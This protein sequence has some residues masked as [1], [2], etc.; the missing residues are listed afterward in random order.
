MIV[1]VGEVQVIPLVRL[2]SLEVRVKLA[3]LLAKGRE[4]K[5]RLLLA[6]APVI[7]AENLL[8]V[9]RELFL[10]L[11]PDLFQEHP[12]QVNDAQLDLRPG[13]AFPKILFQKVCLSQ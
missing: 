1:H 11:G 3:P 9:I 4:A 6:I 7:R 12:L 13:E 8:E 5:H 10:V 2:S